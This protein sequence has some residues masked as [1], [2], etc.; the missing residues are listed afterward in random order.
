MD[1]ERSKISRRKALTGLIVLPALAGLATVAGA[2]YTKSS[3]DA[4]Q[5]QGVPHNGQHCSNCRVF[6]PGKTPDSMGTCDLVE[7]A[8]SPN[9]WCRVFVAKSK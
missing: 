6:H 7:G 8:I 3:K 4:L 2:A 1:H 9:G 5:Y